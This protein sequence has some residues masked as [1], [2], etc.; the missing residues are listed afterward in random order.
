MCR[1][2]GGRQ[3]QG[4]VGVY[5]VDDAVL[6]AAP[7]GAPTGAGRVIVPAVNRMPTAELSADRR[8]KKK[9][10]TVCSACQQY[11][12]ALGAGF[13]IVYQPAFINRQHSAVRRYGDTAAGFRQAIR[14]FYR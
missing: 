13:V 11:V 10:R 4:R 2:D 12:V 3:G 14:Q 8:V 9:N 6:S 5:L 1:L 7:A